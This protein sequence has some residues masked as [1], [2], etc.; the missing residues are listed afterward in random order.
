MVSLSLLAGRTVIHPMFKCKHTKFNQNVII[1]TISISDLLPQPKRSVVGIR[2][3]ILLACCTVH[4]FPFTTNTFRRKKY[5][6]PHL[7]CRGCVKGQNICLHGV[8]CFIPFNLICNMTS[9]RKETK[10][11]ILTPPQG[12]RVYIRAKYLLACY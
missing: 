8:L 1:C 11:D 10:V 6:D 7:R 9:F 12:S 2:S 4:F 3:N 5:F